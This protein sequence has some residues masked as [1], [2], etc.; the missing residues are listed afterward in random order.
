VEE[1][2]MWVAALSG[3]IACANSKVNIVPS[4]DMNNVWSAWGAQSKQDKLAPQR[5]NGIGLA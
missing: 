4:T 5:W 3:A 1:R 2:M